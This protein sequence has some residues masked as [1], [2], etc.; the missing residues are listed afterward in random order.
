MVEPINQPT[1]SVEIRHFSI[2]SGGPL[3]QLLRKIRLSGASL[4][5]TQRR[6]L[7]VS[8]LAWLPLLLLSA[9]GGNAL[10]GVIKVPFL[11]D[12]DVY[13]RFLVALPVLIAAEGIV[14]ARVW[15]A[16]QQFL[17]RRIVLQPDLPAFQS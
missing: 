10:G 14:H 13:V 11:Y 5:L 3:F 15:P 16:I 4:E 8:F 1:E 12:I 9:F 17:T 6:M 7:V 2:V